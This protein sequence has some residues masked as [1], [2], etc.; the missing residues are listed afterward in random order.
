MDC[1]CVLTVNFFLSTLVMH[2]LIHVKFK[3]ELVL[4]EMGLLSVHINDF[5]I[6][7]SKLW[8]LWS[9]CLVSVSWFAFH[10]ILL[11]LRTHWRA[12]IILFNCGLINCGKTHLKAQTNIFSTLEWGGILLPPTL[13]KIPHLT[14]KALNG[15]ARSYL[16]ELIVPL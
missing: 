11:L 14:Y 5:A 6:A 7:S 13:F 8:L 12:V 15:Q 10:L 1:V 16:K 3:I 4:F 2:D 9:Y